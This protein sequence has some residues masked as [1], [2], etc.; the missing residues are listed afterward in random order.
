YNP[1]FNSLH[2]VLAVAA[3]ADMRKGRTRVKKL[4]KA[5]TDTENTELFTLDEVVGRK[6]RRNVNR[7]VK[8]LL[9]NGINFNEYKR[10]RDGLETLRK[11]EIKSDSWTQEKIN[12]LKA[13]NDTRAKINRSH[14]RYGKE[15]SLRWLD[16]RFNP[17]K[18]AKATWSD[19]KSGKPLRILKA[20]ADMYTLGFRPIKGEI[21]NKVIRWYNAG[22]AGTAIVETGKAIKEGRPGTAAANIADLLRMRGKHKSDDP[23]P[24]RGVEGGH[25]TPT[26]PFRRR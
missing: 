3:R 9:T 13:M 26:T 6:N 20:A 7:Q 1:K 11:V 10:M 2:Q 18:I 5:W 25:T 23:V 19:L 15:S 21:G 24:T 12:F 8:R 4:H 22:R 16:Q 17:V 14:G